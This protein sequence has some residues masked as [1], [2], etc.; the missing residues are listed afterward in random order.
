MERIIL[1]LSGIP[2]SGKSTLI[3][4]LTQEEAATRFITDS[5]FY[6]PKKEGFKALRL[7]WYLTDFR[8]S[9]FRTQLRPIRTFFQQDKVQFLKKELNILRTIS[10]YRKYYAFNSIALSEGLIQGCFEILDRVDAER[11]DQA[12]RCCCDV[13]GLFCREFPDIRFYILT[14]DP[15]AANSRIN[16]RNSSD[17]SVD[18]ME[19]PVR[20]AFLCKRSDNCRLL[21]DALMKTGISDQIHILDASMTAEDSLQILRKTM[22]R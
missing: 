21:C 10:L 9:K 4:G 7:F 6:P 15:A 17:N 1:E 16:G 19:N 8:N 2:G 11:I 18:C 13:L 3:E 5:D 12:V 14:L 20:E 22:K